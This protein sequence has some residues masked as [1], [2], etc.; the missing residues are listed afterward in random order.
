MRYDEH[1]PLNSII[2][3]GLLN[4]YFLKWKED[5]GYKNII[6]NVIVSYNRAVD[7]KMISDPIA[8]NIANLTKPFEQ[9]IPQQAVSSNAKVKYVLWIKFFKAYVMA[10]MRSKWRS[11]YVKILITKI[12]SLFIQI[13]ILLFC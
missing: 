13:I 11:E 1:H 6:N 4:K 3:Q 12:L 9:N 8:W 7:V 2:E 5:D 10:Y